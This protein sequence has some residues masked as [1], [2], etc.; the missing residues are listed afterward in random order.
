MDGDNSDYIAPLQRLEARTRYCKPGLS[1][2]QRINTGQCN[3]SGKAPSHKLL[4][5]CRGLGVFANKRLKGVVGRK[6][7]GILRGHSEAEDEVPGPQ[8]SYSSLVRNERGIRWR[9]SL[10]S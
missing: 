1:H 4:P 5:S 7:D 2:V 10:S 9:F 8:G 3:H 6:H